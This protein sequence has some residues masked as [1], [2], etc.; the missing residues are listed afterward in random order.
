MSDSELEISFDHDLE[1]QTFDALVGKR[2]ATL[3]YRSNKEGKIFLT[4]T[5]VHPTLQGKGVE[6]KL[7]VHVLEYIREN[8]MRLIPVCPVVKEFL[9]THQEYM[10]VV[11]SGIRIN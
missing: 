8:G 1:R 9:K 4:S 6:E 7:V 10:D 11:A 5:E 3:E 2:R